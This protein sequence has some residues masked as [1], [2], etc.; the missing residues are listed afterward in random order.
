MQVDI[1]GVHYEL[2]DVTKE[3]LESK[4]E[5]LE[6]AEDLVIGL[7][8]TL[9]K[10][11]HDWK[12]EARI[13]FKWGATAFMDETDLNLHQSIEKLIDRLDHKITKEKQKVQDHHKQSHQKLEP[14]P[15]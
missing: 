3:F 13:N 10:G 9:I 7:I 5:K 14:L 12:A 4:L 6:Y 8:I 2:T 11:S 15:E 1:K